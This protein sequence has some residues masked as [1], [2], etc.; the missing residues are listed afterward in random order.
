MPRK[1]TVT[2]APLGID[3]GT[4]CGAS[5]HP[6]TLVT[7]SALA[8]SGSLFNGWSG[9]GCTG[10]G[11]CQVTMD[12]AKSVSATFIRVCGALG[13]ATGTGTLLLGLL[14][15]PAVMRRSRRYRGGR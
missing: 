15:K 12:A 9:A 14:I 8:T 3:R 5:F 2:S 6:E 1:G 7:S 11:T 10:T 13:F 4:T